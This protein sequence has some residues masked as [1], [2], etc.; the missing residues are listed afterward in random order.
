MLAERLSPERWHQIDALFAE[1][2]ERSPHERPAFLEVATRDDPELRLEVEQLLEDVQPAESLLGESVS[3]YAEPFLIR[4]QAELSDEDARDVAPGGRIGP[5]RVLRELGRGGMGAVFLAERADDAFEKQVALKLVKRGMDTDEVLRRFRYERQILASLEHP[6]IARLYD[7]GAAEDGR[8]YLVMEHIEGRPV[9]AYCDERRQPLDERVRLFET[10]CEAVQF[11]HRNLVVHRDIKPSNILVD[12]SGTVKLLDFGIAKLLVPSDSDTAVETRAELRPVTPEYASPEQLAGRPVTTASDVYALGVV[13]YELL[14]G[15]RPRDRYSR[16]PE[17]NRRSSA[18]SETERPSSV[19]ERPLRQRPGEVQPPTPADIAGR[20]G[21]T[22]ERLRRRLLGDLDTISLTAL[23]EEPERR[24]QSAEQLLADVRRYLNGYPVLARGESM[25]YRAR[26]FVRRHTLAVGFSAALG[27]LAAAF[28]AATLLQAQEV[29]RART[30]AEVRQGQAEDLIGFMLGDLRGKLDP[31][32]RLD[33]LRDVGSQ[34]LEYFAAVPPDQLSDEELF[35]R[36]E[37][38]RLVGHVQRDQGDWEAAARTYGE[39]LVLAGGLASRDSLHGDWQLGLGAS[40][41]YL[42]LL[43]Y[44]QGDANGSLEYWRRYRDTAERLVRHAPDS[45]RYQL[46]LSAAHGNI[47]SAYE[48]LGDL[49]HAIEA[50]RLALELKER[51]VELEPENPEY[52]SA[53]AT[54]YNKMALARIKEGDLSA[55]LEYQ[56]AELEVRQSIVRVDSANH[57]QRRLLALAH[58]WLGE[59]ATAAGLDDEGREH[60]LAAWELDRSLVRRDSSNVVWRR[61]LA[62]T[63]RLAGVG[64]SQVGLHDASLEALESSRELLLQLVDN[65]P[66]SDGYRRELGKTEFEIAAAYRRGGRADMALAAAERALAAIEPVRTQNPEDGASRRVHSNANL[67]LGRALARLGRD[68]DARVAW[69]RALAAIR[70]V[71]Q[72]SGGIGPVSTLAFA[73]LLLDELDEARSVVDTLVRQGYRRS[74]FLALARHK[75]VFSNEDP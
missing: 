32:G 51:L 35:R 17:A 10:I 41:F 24:Y 60:R 59:W 13:F 8:P 54:A 25:L 1:A 72:E 5:Y 29:A 37:A 30:I 65:N 47:G 12:A 73:L 22:S 33:V 6:N 50:Y 61:E 36:S 42:G 31:I 11:A 49:E 14:T 28:T 55:A 9:T 40:Y 48:A 69:R 43:R 57:E 63:A 44:L 71:A 38:L 74:E 67:E 68:T 52:Q 15:R 23:A 16:A 21:T 62:I 7:G 18:A 26:K 4:L 46:E 45:A 34:A 58:S 19:V 27:L 56:R 75:G 64:L 2:L 66:E 53:L 20:R 39:S 70:P 3:Q